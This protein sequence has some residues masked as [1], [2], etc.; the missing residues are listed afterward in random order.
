MLGFINNVI[1]REMETDGNRDRY[2]KEVE[3]MKPVDKETNNKHLECY[4]VLLFYT[5]TH[6]HTHTHIYIYIYIWRK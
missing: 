6:I 5:H 2:R 1:G 3:N 4:F